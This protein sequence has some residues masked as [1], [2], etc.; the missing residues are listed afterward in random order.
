M[1]SDPDP[2]QDIADLQSANAEKTQVKRLRSQVAA[3]ERLVEQQQQRIDKLS[4]QKVVAPRQPSSS[5]MPVE[6]GGFVRVIVPDTHGC[7]IDQPAADAMLSDIKSLD[8]REIVMIG[9]HIDCGGFLAQHHVWGYVAEAAYTFEED[10]AAANQFLD[11]LQSAAPNATIHYLEGNHEARIEKWCVTQALRDGTDAAFLLGLLGTEKILHLKKRGINFYAQGKCYAGCRIP[12]T[13]KLGKCYFTHGTKH[14]KRAAD[15]ML[16]RFGASVVFGH[17]HKL[18]SAS[19]RTVKD[20]E[21]GAWSVGCLCSLQPKWRHSDPTD[22]MHGYGTQLVREN[23]DFLHINVPVIN[24][25]S[26]LVPF[27]QAAA[28]I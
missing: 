3:Y 23:G 2:L 1:S 11:S 24:A 6:P 22:W 25:E 14:G 18:L 17:V 26:F 27:T 9:D 28:A 12:S 15:Q 13:I 20:G 21:I 7:F 16:Q 10:V 4:A 8:P 19:D 5:P